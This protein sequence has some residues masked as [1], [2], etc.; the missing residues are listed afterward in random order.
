MRLMVSNMALTQDIRDNNI[1]VGKLSIADQ[2]SKK[3]ILLTYQLA[4][5]NPGILD[6]YI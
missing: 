2:R 5:L 1:T 4:R 3:T 6:L